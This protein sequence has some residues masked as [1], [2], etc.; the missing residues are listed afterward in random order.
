[1]N[2]GQNGMSSAETLSSMAAS[3]QPTY[4]SEP[5]EAGA[6]AGWNGTQG[7]YGTDM[8]AYMSGFQAQNQQHYYSPGVV[9]PYGN[10]MPTVQTGPAQNPSEQSWKFQVL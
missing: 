6:Y 2:F 9:Q 4:S 10:S 3:A 5:P 1:M 7:F 8:N